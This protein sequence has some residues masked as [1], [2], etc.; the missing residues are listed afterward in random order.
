MG[1][2]AQAADLDEAAATAPRQ[3]PHH[4]VQIAPE[5][6]IVSKAALLTC[7]KGAAARSRSMAAE[8]RRN[9]TGPVA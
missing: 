7:A 1:G 8:P 5:A 9:S 6:L 4:Q 3:Y 2:S